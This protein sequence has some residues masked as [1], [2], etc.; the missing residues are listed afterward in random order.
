MYYSAHLADKHSQGSLVGFL[1]C[2]I[3]GHLRLHASCKSSTIV[4]QFTKQIG[5]Q[6]KRYRTYTLDCGL[7]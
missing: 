5:T 1:V 2:W 3:E 7:Y 4:S 6:Q